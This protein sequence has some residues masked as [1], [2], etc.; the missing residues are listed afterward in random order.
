[1]TDRAATPSPSAAPDRVC[2]GGLFFSS[3]RPL[4]GPMGSELLARG[5]LLG[6]PLTRWTRSRPDAVQTVHAAYAAAGAQWVTTNTFLAHAL[7]EEAPALVREAVA[8]ARSAAPSLPVAVSLGPGGASHGYAR[9]A[10]AAADAGADLLLLET[11]TVLS[12]ARAALGAVVGVGLPVAVLLVFDE[13]GQTLED[14]APARW[15]A[16]ALAEAGAAAVGANCQPPDALGRCVAEMAEISPLVPII[17]RPSAGI[18]R[19]DGE[20][21]LYPWLPETWAAATLAL[22]RAGAA[23]LGGCCG[24]GPAHIR[25]LARLLAA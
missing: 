13:R 12:A 15:A 1:M 14:T 3:N 8:L 6:E 9:L 4:D 23:L 20:S 22:Q 19:V 2:V 16:A 18:P 11:F 21:A 17:V 5:G 24:A 10:G 7:P 25:A